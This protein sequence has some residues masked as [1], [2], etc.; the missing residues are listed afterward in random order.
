[1]WIKPLQIFVRQERVCGPVQ[2]ILQSSS[3]GKDCGPAIEQII[4]EH[5]RFNIKSVQGKLETHLRWRDGQELLEGSQRMTCA[6]LRCDELLISDDAFHAP[7]QA[8]SDLF[9]VFCQLPGL[10]CYLKLVEM[11]F[12]DVLKLAFTN[13]PAG[14]AEVLKKSKIKSELETNNF[15]L[16]IGDKLPEELHGNLNHAMDVNYE[17][18]APPVGADRFP[19]KTPFCHTP[20]LQGIG[21]GDMTTR[22][23]VGE[24]VIAEVPEG[25]FI[26]ARVAE[27]KENFEED[28]I[29]TQRGLM[30]R[31]RVQVSKKKYEN[32]GHQYLYKMSG[33]VSQTSRSLQSF[34]SCLVLAG[35]CNDAA[36]EASLD[37]QVI[38]DEVKTQL[39]D[40]AKMESGHYKKALRRLFLRWHPDKAGNTPFNNLIFRMLL[41][42]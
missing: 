8:V 20:S 24:Y 1:M 40:M 14:I 19:Q 25:E 10:V 37:R 13:G 5:F 12:K 2:A 6:A 23:Q 26:V 15:C 18:R 33:G 35:P 22:V 3:C 11:P 31:Y 17:A 42:A 7:D 9:A 21:L 30:R 16:S 39:R 29:R 41:G 27:W 32:L 38:L 28:S 34:G 36:D 4:K